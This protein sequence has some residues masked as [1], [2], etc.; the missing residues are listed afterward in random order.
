MSHTGLLRF[1]TCGSVDDGKSTLIGRLLYDAGL[2][3]ED[4]LAGLI[5]NGDGPDCSRLLDGLMA[6]REQGITID[7]AYRQFATPKRH[8]M[9]A[10]SPGHEEYTPNMVTA[11]SHVEV[12]VLLTD[13]SKGVLIQTRRH[14]AIAHLMGID[15]VLL[16]VNKMDLISYSE[17]KFHDIEAQFKTISAEL[18]I[19]SVLCMPVCAKSGDNVVKKSEKMSWYKGPSLLEWLENVQPVLKEKPLPFRMAVQWVNRPD[20]SFRGVSGTIAA[21]TIKKGENV[22]LLDT[23]I[24]TRIKSILGADGEV[25]EEGQGAPVTLTF[26]EEIDAG[27]GSLIVASEAPKPLTADRIEADIIWLGREPL[28]IGRAY[29]FK[30]GPVERHAAV[31][32]VYGRLDLFSFQETDASTIG[33]N[34]QGRVELELVPP[35]PFEPYEAN[36]QMGHGIL[37]DRVSGGTVGA[38]LLRRPAKNTRNVSWHDFSVS[39]AD[40]ARSMGQRPYVLWFT[41]LSGAGKSTI[42]DIVERKLYAMGRHTFVLDGDNVRHGLN[43]DLGFSP[44]DRVENIRRVAEVA[45]LLMDAGLIVLVTF[46]SPFAADRRMAR[47]LFPKDSFFEIFVDTPL[48]ICMER[49]VKSLYKRAVAGE[50]KDMTGLSSP[51]EKPVHPDLVLDGKNKSPEELANEVLRLIEKN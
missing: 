1:L 28:Q 46:I 37:I 25:E 16:A 51:Y 19:S 22:T 48:S 15:T 24:T 8:F 7:V 17:E 18:G 44:A 12:A 45:K 34:E 3:C 9:V 2:V 26:E 14:A 20:S 39:N 27:R 31:V 47:S 11:A 50:I 36:K 49:D 4:H 43:R 13:A 35:L 5:S 6:E 42:A 40:R 29:V 30:R 33:V 10:D 38:L 41:G 32:T 23:G 21:G